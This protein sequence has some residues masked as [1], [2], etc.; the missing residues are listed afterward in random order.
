MFNSLE[1][2]QTSS[3]NFQNQKRQAHGLNVGTFLNT[4]D[5]ACLLSS[6]NYLFLCVE[7]NCLPIP[8]AVNYT[9]IVSVEQDVTQG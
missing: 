6:I 5:E 1:Y 2:Q 7:C 4:K 8:G 9:R 3:N